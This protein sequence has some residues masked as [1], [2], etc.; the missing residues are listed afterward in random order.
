LLNTDAIVE[1]AA[2]KSEGN[3]SLNDSLIIFN[4]SFAL[5]SPDLLLEFLLAPDAS[6]VSGIIYGS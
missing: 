6:S 5:V 1:E 3:P 2:C 4:I